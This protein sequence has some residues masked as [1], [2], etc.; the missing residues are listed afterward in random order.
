MTGT[1]NDGWDE[2]GRRDAELVNDLITQNK[3]NLAAA[4]S[5]TLKNI[6]MSYIVILTEAKNRLEQL[7]PPKE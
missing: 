5:E 6:Y 7:D 4:T 1:F 2:R 3:A